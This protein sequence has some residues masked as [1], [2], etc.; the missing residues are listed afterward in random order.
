[1]NK[2]FILLTACFAL[3]A[4]DKA[5]EKLSEKAIEKAIESQMSKDGKT[6]N[7]TIGKDGIQA[8]VTD[9]NGNVSDVVIGKDGL[10]TKTTDANGTVTNASIGTDGIKST[11]TD[12][13]GKVSTSEFGSANVTEADVGIPF[14]PGAS[15]K[16]GKGSKMAGPDNSMIMIT[17]ESK[18]DLDKV[19]EYYRGKFKGIAKGR[20]LSDMSQAGESAM[21]ALSDDKNRDN[22]TVSVS[23]NDDAKLTEINI[24]VSKDTKAN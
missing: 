21:L 24:M 23:K 3:N 6:A 18:D 8:K 14:Y 17:L 4:C 5:I 7:V 19:A 16:D 12:A 2:L 22:L 11:S 1:M 10:Q 20:K 13:S 9:A 15:I